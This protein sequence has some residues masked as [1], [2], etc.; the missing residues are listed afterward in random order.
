MDNYFLRKEVSNSDLTALKMRLSAREPVDYTAAFRFGNLI[1][2]MITTN[3]RVDY[4]KYTVG[5]ERY[6]K[7]EFQ[8][9]EKMKRAYFQ[10]EYCRSLLPTEIEKQKIDL[11]R[12]DFDFNGYK[13]SLDCRCKWDLWLKQQGFGGDIKSTVAETQQQFESAVK[14]FDMD[15]QRA[16]YMDIGGSDM[17][18]IIGI[19]KKNFKVFK[20]FINRESDIYKSGRDKYVYL[21]FKWHLIYG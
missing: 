10:D 7:Q 4:R 15:R 2:A 20:I 18:V 11:R 13:F 6:T 12:L 5:N 8:L 16:F 1:D 3:N 14:Y 19:S 9:A 17:D 21:A